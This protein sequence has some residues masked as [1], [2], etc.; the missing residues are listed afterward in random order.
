MTSY[1]SKYQVWRGRILLSIF[2]GYGSLYILREMLALVIKPIEADLNLTRVQAGFIPTVFYIAY[3]FGKFVSGLIS[4]TIDP[5]KLLATSI[6]MT[7]VTGGLGMCLANSY[8]AILLFW[9]VSGWFQAMGWPPCARLISRWYTV[10]ERGYIW[11]LASTSHMI[12]AGTTAALFPT[13][14]EDFGWRYAFITA[15]A[16]CSSCAMVVYMLVRRSPKSV[17]LKN[18]EEYKEKTFQIEREHDDNDNIKYIDAFKIVIKNR[19][20][21]LL[22]VGICFM[23]II[24]IGFQTWAPTYLQE[25]K[26]MSPTSAGFLVASFSYVGA[27]GGVVAGRLSD[28]LFGG[29]RSPVITG[30]GLAL[31]SCLIIFNQMNEINS[32]GMLCFALIGFFIFGPQVLLSVA[33]IDYVDS[34]V[35]STA[36][37][38]V[39]AASAIGSTLASIGPAAIQTRFGWNAVII[40]FIICAITVIIAVSFLRQPERQ[41]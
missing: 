7:A 30:Y 40:F 16:V 15:A 31:L 13:I 37:G 3:T 11:G 38:V 32:G 1:L 33:S 19:N 36:N 6:F 8:Y 26:N 5:R 17:G 10:D 24:R 4:D 23:Y 29:Y 9:G 25:D 18:P 21:W 27:I 14:I 35:T 34:R 39:G 28:R 22:S 20:I 2:I 41:M 12:G